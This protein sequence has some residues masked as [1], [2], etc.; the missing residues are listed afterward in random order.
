MIYRS[1][2]LLITCLL[3]SLIDLSD[4][5]ASDSKII[6][7]DELDVST[8]KNSS[9]KIVET[10][11]QVKMKENASPVS[12][13]FM[14]PASA[15]PGMTIG[16]TTFDIQSYGRMNRQ[17]DWRGNQMV[18]F[19]WMKQLNSELGGDRGTG[20]EAWDS[21]AGTLSFMGYGGGCDIHPRL[22]IGQNYSGYVGLDVDTEGKVVIGNHHDEGDG[23]ASTI[24]YDFSP[25][26]CF[27]SPYRRRVPDSSM[28]YGLPP[29]DVG[30]SSGRMIWPQIE[31]Q[32]WGG[33]SVTHVFAR[34]SIE[35]GT[36]PA[37]ITYY[38][39]TGSDTLG[40]WEYPPMVVDTTMVIGQCV[41][42]SRV[43][44][45]A[46]LIWLAPPGNYPGDPESVTRDWEDI[47][48]GSSQRINDIYY[49]ISTDLGANWQPK[50][51]MTAYDSSRGGYLAE[52]D[53]SV[54]IDS[55]DHL[56]ALWPAR[57]INSAGYSGSLGIYTNFYGSR[58]LHW[59]E[60]NNEIRT[61]REANWDITTE[62]IR[63]STCTGGP[64]NEMSLGKPMLSECDGKFYAVFVQFQNLYNGIYNDCSAARWS[65][66]GPSGTANAE[67][68]ISVSDNGGFNWDYA[69]NL[70]NTY[71]PFCDTSGVPYE[72]ES[73]HY[74]SVSRF[75]MQNNGAD[76]TGVP[77]VDPSGGGYGGDYFLDVLYVNDKY[78][79]SVLEGKG[80]WTTNSVKWFRVPC[81]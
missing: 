56:H 60:L 43:S 28:E 26:A 76:F 2:V 49:M 62:V 9:V 16:Y 31:Y 45:K 63:D 68:Y 24:W 34:Q 52:S 36:D 17:V 11:D 4:C 12:L 54:L 40:Y 30:T 71:T 27:F 42:A 55:Q 74:P 58:L 53:I 46:A 38:R 23:Y 50:L 15:S 20:Y 3:L 79:G 57:V 77:V 48:L 6:K 1:V 33:D 29:A 32:V 18:H 51:N 75:G 64:W 65:G 14:E 69:R 5:Y 19:I 73:D 61:V 47:D 7:G 70:T 35:P 41:T 72:C 10:I 39:R 66:A 80:C 37:I 25:A 22:G 44:G 81:V 8:V 78:P 59:D 13:G 21:D 67:L